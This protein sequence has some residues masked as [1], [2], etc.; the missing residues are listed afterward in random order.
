LLVTL[1]VAAEVLISGWPST[2]VWAREVA[3][4]A[5]LAVELDVALDEV[6]S[7]GGVGRATAADDALLDDA[8]ATPALVS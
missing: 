8:F 2:R 6:W 1:N 4:A 7:Q 3:L 5:V